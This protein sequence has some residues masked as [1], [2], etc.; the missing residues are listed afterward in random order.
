MGPCPMFRAA[1]HP[2]K[3][4]MQMFVGHRCLFVTVAVAAVTAGGL[5]ARPPAAVAQ[6]ASIAAHHGPA[7]TG[8][9]I[10]TILNQGVAQANLEPSLFRP[11]PTTR[12]HLYSVDRSRPFIA[13]NSMT[14]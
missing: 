13:G 12:I 4:G 7:L 11:K 8:A 5:I 10:Q 6:Q 9:E 3:E 14:H 1:L 2:L